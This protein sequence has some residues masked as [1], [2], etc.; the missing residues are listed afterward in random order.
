MA[1]AATFSAMKFDSSR[2][3]AQAHKG[4]IYAK[5]GVNLKET[6]EKTKI[7]LCSRRGVYF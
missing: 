5:I 3:G 4:E 7:Y 2:V 1:S 6:D